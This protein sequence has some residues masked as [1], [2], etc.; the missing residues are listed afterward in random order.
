MKTKL[1]T[2]IISVLIVFVLFPHYVLHHAIGAFMLATIIISGGLL[3]WLSRPQK[4]YAESVRTQI[5]IDNRQ[6][7]NMTPVNAHE[8][9]QIVEILKGLGY[10]TQESKIVAQ[11]ALM[12]TQSG[13]FQ[14]KVRKAVQ[15][16]DKN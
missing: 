9:E 14:D 2:A 15:M 13:N 11:Q 1:I 4:I 12:D 7:S 6:T 5:K 3:Y 16:L 8:F 10:K